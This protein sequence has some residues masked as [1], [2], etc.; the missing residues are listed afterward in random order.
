M[1]N[2]RRDMT[3]LVDQ[4]VVSAGSFGITMVFIRGAGLEEFGVLSLVWLVLLFA[5]ALQHA[6]VV[7]PAYT[8]L[9]K[10]EGPEGSRFR[11]WLLCVHLA[12]VAL[13]IGVLWACW[14][15]PGFSLLP[16]SPGF[17]APGLFLASRLTFTFVRFQ[18]FVGESGPRRALPVDALHAFVAIAWLLSLASSGALNS[19]TG[20]LGLAGA[21]ACGTLV[22]IPSFLGLGCSVGG[23]DRGLLLR[24]WQFSR[25]LIGKAVAQ[26][27]TA[28]SFLAALGTIHGPI[29]L[30]G[31]RAAQT[32]VG[33]AGIIPQSFEN[34]VPVAAARAF[35]AGRGTQL[36]EFMRVSV[37][38]WF[39]WL[40]ALLLPV[41][42]FPDFLLS[43]LTGERAVELRQPVY[44]FAF[45]SLLAFAV[46]YCH[47][48]LRAAERVGTLFWAQLASGLAGALLAIPITAR[49]GMTGCL[50]GIVA[51]QVLVL[52]ILL[53]PTRQVLRAGHSATNGD[54]KQRPKPWEG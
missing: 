32:V 1:I 49:F 50:I 4:G 52:T 5:S 29:A 34:V 3:A 37:W 31:V 41:I 2:T 14:L 13:L 26:W 45:G 23:V 8:L 11:G 35:G 42:V 38:R 28:N 17:I 39:G 44:F 46:M 54:P 21:S 53:L 33:L 10:I 20:L 24:H 15:A 16:A 30:G 43:L 27:F 40:A 36:R 48:C 18:L 47:V 22:A 9:P 51:Q 19:R 25:W 7:A 12:F 6:L